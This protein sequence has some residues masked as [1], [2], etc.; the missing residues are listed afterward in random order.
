MTV[1]L[2]KPTILNRKIL[3]YAC[4]EQIIKVEVDKKVI[5]VM[6]I[7][8]Y[9][10]IVNDFIFIL[11]FLSHGNNHN[12]FIGTVRLQIKKLSKVKTKINFDKSSMDD[13]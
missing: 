3:C 1:Y 7:T 9:L 5:E 2:L 10:K 13:L 8:K 11:C 4:H 6:N 12:I